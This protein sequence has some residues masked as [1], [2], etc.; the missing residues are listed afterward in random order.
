MSLWPAAGWIFGGL[1]L[2]LLTGS[3]VGFLWQRCAPGPAISQVNARIR[4]WWVMI[5]LMGFGLWAGPVAI[6][7]FFF[8][9]SLQA[10][11]EFGA[12]TPLTVVLLVAQ[13]GVV[14][15]GL[16]PAIVL[17][18]M[19]VP[20]Q[21]WALVLGV[22]GLA[23]LPALPPLLMVFVVLIAQA[24]DVFQF[25]FGKALGRHRL[26]PT[27]SPQKT[28]EGLVG[29]LVASAA[30]GALVY[31]LTPFSRGVAAAMALAICA[32]GTAGGLI[33]SAMKRQ[34]GIKDWGQM[35]E[36]HGGVLDRADSVC[37]SAPLLYYWL[38]LF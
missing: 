6:Y 33:L 17:P 7:G 24:G 32:A 2:A 10:L 18:A 25:L 36:G 11:R 13:Y 14:F 27:I 3:L 37:L 35:I 20:R 16:P 5:T 15:N 21:R 26:A 29:G 22:A 1:Y 4:G 9:L 19:L 31:W 30:L 34:R 12:L 38:K 8:L 23:H 28:I